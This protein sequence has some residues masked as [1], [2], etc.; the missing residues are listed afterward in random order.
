MKPY[1]REILG[2]MGSDGCHLYSIRLYM[3]G[4]QSVSEQAEEHIAPL[5]AQVKQAAVA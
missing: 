3:E 2:F 5:K 1:L 4:G